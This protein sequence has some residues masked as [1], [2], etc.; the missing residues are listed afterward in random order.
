MIFKTID[1]L[2]LIEELVVDCKS[3]RFNQAQVQTCTVEPLRSL[4]GTDSDTPF[5]E[6]LLN[7]EANLQHISLTKVT[8]RYLGSLTKNK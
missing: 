2:T 5:S 3:H 4:L 1:N 6:A 8:K 7:G